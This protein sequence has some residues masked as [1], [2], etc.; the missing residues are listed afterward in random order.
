MTLRADVYTA[1]NLAYINTNGSLF[2]P[3]GGKSHAM[4][5]RR[6]FNW[7]EDAILLNEEILQLP[8]PVHLTVVCHGMVIKC[9]LHHIL[10][11]GDRFIWR[12]ELDNCSL[13]RLCFRQEGWFPLCI[14]NRCHL[15]PWPPKETP[16]S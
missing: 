5:A 2:V 1:E 4:V 15:M 14:N 6:A 13:S 3:V 11:F 12:F 16:G 8:M 9:V 10:R 7:I